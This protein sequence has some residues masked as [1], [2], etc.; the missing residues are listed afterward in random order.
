[1]NDPLGHQIHTVLAM[2]YLFLLPVATAP[3]DPALIVLGMWWVIRLRHTWRSYLEFWRHPLVIALIAWGGWEALSLTWSSDPHG[4][5]DELRAYRMLIT[6]VLLWPVLDRIPWL[7]GAALLGILAQNGFQLLQAT[8]V[9]HRPR[10]AEGRFGGLLHPGNTAALCV[11]AMCWGLSAIMRSRGTWRW[12]SVLLAAAA[13]AG[14]VAT[15]ARGPWIAAAISLP[16]MLLIVAIR[17]PTLRRSALIIGGAVLVAAAAAWP[18]IHQDVVQRFD[19]ARE[20][21]RNADENGV[22]W[23]SV[24][25]RI[26]MGK[27]ALD[28]FRDHPVTGVGAGGFLEAKQ[29]HPDY[30]AAMNRARNEH[31]QNWL[32]KDHPHSLYL[33]TLACNG[34]IGAALLLIVIFFALRQCWRDPPTHIYADGTLFALISWLI[35]AQFDS[36][37]L[38]G[39]IMGLFGFIV[40]ITMPGRAAIRAAWSA[41]DQRDTEPALATGATTELI[42]P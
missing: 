25:L 21:A 16:L 28:I 12:I 36:Y 38:N 32:A 34:G 5:F 9:S 17:R 23:T 40:A 10:E 1:M 18:M 39:T 33:Y 29:S 22:Y 30:M 24:G 14:L 19:D 27:W 31:Q 11:A 20:Q 26:A 37:N 6:P 41:K 4:G 2:L 3:K 13:A 8:G 15:E 7:I 42:A 35:G